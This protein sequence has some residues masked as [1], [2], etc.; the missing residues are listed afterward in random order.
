MRNKTVGYIILAISIVIAFIIFSFNQAL[1][2]MAAASCT[3]GDSCPMWGT[4]DFQTNIS[5]GLNIFIALIG[6]YFIFFAK[7]QTI[8]KKIVKKQVKIEK[9]SKKHYSDIMKR[10]SNDEKLVFEKIFDSG[11]SIYQSNLIKGTNFSK[12][13]MTRILDKLETRRLIERKRRGMTNIV[14][15]KN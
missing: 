15:L 6:L 7:E 10:L 14:V 12:V 5:L 1:I 3:M 9:P 11:G 13:K 2:E 8:V 4:I